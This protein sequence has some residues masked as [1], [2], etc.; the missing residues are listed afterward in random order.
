MKKK[1][2]K[3]SL[4]VIVPLVL[5]FQNCVPGELEQ[6]P[7]DSDSQAPETIAFDTVI[8]TL[9]YMSCTGMDRDYNKKA[10]YTFKV[11]AYRLGSGIG[12]S[13]QFFES[14]KFYSLENKIK[15]IKETQSG[16][17]V[18][19]QMGIHQKGDYSK[20]FGIQSESAYGNEFYNT[21]ILDYLFNDVYISQIAQLKQGLYINY[22][23][24]LPDFEGKIIE[25]QLHLSH[26]SSKSHSQARNFLEGTGGSLT[27]VTL[28]YTQSNL[29]IA[30]LI[31]PSQIPAKETAFGRGY[32][33]SFTSG[34]RYDRNDPSSL[35]PT[36]RNPSASENH[37]KTV[38]SRV[39][40]IDLESGNQVPFE[41][42]CPSE[43]RFMIFRPYDT[44]PPKDDDSPSPHKN[45]QF[46]CG[47]DDNGVKISV[48][49]RHLTPEQKSVYRIL[50][51]EDWV[52]DFKRRCVVPKQ[53][54]SD[55]YGNVWVGRD[56]SNSED[57]PNSEINSVVNYFDE[58]E[59]GYCGP[60]VP[61]YVHTYNDPERTPPYN[62][63]FF[64]IL[65]PRYVSVCVRNNVLN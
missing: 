47:L 37:I 19:L 42:E 12:L 53:N 51:P 61:P 20:T 28:G 54:G 8:D 6:T 21:N 15:R 41:W 18:R 58:F 9:S 22:F 60:Y 38:L 4:V 43:Y 46:P 63:R 2:F 34:H 29:E 64:Q 16:L 59:N 44:T 10:Y 17:G 23:K 56:G 27:I 14:I 55:C 65:C 30:S 52:I 7:I 25:S 50:R 33:L 36:P 3:W 49:P 24:G 1:R 39:V 13:P 31:G 32:K 48:E 11:G 26:L 5:I 40:E 35:H 62:T 45:M 57:H